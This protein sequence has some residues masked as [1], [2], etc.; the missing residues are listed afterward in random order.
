M[1]INR[2]F[3]KM[4][5]SELAQVIIDANRVLE[6]IEHPGFKLLILPAIKESLA[7][8][9]SAG[10]W[11]PGLTYD[12]SQVALCNAFN[13]GRKSGLGEPGIIVQ[14][15]LKDKEEARKVLAQRKEKEKEKEKKI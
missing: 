9:V 11:R 14:E 13:S 3:S 2:H 5:E 8:A 10:D 6:A 4:T 1:K 15:F 12:V 7:V